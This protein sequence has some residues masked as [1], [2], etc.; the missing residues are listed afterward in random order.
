MLGYAVQFCIFVI[1]LAEA[2]YARMKH[3]SQQVYRD[4]SGD[5]AGCNSADNVT[6]AASL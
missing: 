5:G 1:I 3:G 4:P 6:G 2:S